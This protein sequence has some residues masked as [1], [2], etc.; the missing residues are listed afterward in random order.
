MHKGRLCGIAFIATLLSAC[1]SSGGS[2]S[3]G[4]P[5][6]SPQSVTVTVGIVYRG[7]PAP[8]DSD[9][10]VAGTIHLTGTAFDAS[11][12]VTDGHAATF[13]VQPG[14]YTATAR[15]GDAQCRTATV[16]AAAGTKSPVLVRCDVK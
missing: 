2:A 12:H 15:S 9:H 3:G 16:N 1:G 11:R 14:A 4:S 13:R 10:L 8:G 6:P 5:T 7:G